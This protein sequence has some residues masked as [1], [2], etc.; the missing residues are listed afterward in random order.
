MKL[1]SKVTQ[2]V[3]DWL[4]TPEDERDIKAGADLMLSLNRN[5]ALYN[6]ILRRPD[7]FVGKL[8]YELRKH[9]R[10][11]L[12]D[13]TLADVGRKEKEVMPLV[14]ETIGTMPILST[15]DE[16]PEGVVARGRRADHDILPA[17]VQ[18]LWDS[19]AERYRRIVVLFNELKAMND[20]QPCDRFEKVAMLG[21]LDRT[22]REN[23]SLYDSYVPE[24]LP[25]MGG[26]TPDETPSEN[27][28]DE[29]STEGIPSEASRDEVSTDN[30]RII[31]NA[32]KTLS[33]YRKQ[34]TALDGDDPRRQTALEKIQSAVDAIIAC[35]AGVA[36]DTKAELTALGINFG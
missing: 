11:R 28:S 25:P 22:Y 6:S 18:E 9:L 1:D 23:L 2:S 5:R 4:N 17:H 14:Q 3:Q 8:V 15:D 7:K 35:G 27:A 12:A 29:V 21:E 36:D 13:M 16:L 24:S 32:R 19:N 10:I 31:S 26:D 30:V 33:K 34:L 20:L